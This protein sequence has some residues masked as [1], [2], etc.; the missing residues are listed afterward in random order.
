MSWRAA[1]VRLGVCTALAAATYACTEPRAQT[2]AR[3]RERIVVGFT[4]PTEPVYIA[5]LAATHDLVLEV[6][7][8]LRPDL[9]ALDLTADGTC[10]AAL[11]RLR[12]DTSVRDAA[13]ERRR[14]A[15]S[16]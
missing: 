8:R 4:A 5:T 11:E 10:A 13:P 14:R 15:N 6:V 3:C 9:Y 7:A 1:F 2:A 12:T 16:G